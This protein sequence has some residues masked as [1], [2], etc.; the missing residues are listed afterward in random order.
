MMSKSCRQLRNDIYERSQSIS[1]MYTLIKHPKIDNIINIY[2]SQFRPDHLT[3]IG[4]TGDNS[5]S[6]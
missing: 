4:S 5:Q 3:R 2:L 6:Q 1:V